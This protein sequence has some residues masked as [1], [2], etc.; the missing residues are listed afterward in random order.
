MQHRGFSGPFLALTYTFKLA[1][2]L[3]WALP[4]KNPAQVTPKT[5][6]PAAQNWIPDIQA[7]DYK[8]THQAGAAHH[9]ADGLSR[10][11]TFALVSPTAGILYEKLMENPSLCG[12]ASR[13]T[14]GPQEVSR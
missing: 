6:E 10:L 3:C 5:N 12:G 13:D 2:L 14:E 8:I 7:Y 4:T 1:S 11:P 9:N